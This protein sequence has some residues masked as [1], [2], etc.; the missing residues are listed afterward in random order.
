MKNSYLTI[1]LT[2]TSLLGLGISARAQDASRVVVTVP[3]QFVVAGSKTMPAGTYWIERVSRDSHS[4]LIIRS[5]EDS[6]LVLPMAVDGPS[7]EQAELNFEHVGDKY[8]LSRVA[9]LA[10]VYTID[11]PRAITRLAKSKDHGTASSSGN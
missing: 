11:T 2:L 4:G 9:T 5:Y 10:G 6:V 8:F 7:T 1:V 3:F